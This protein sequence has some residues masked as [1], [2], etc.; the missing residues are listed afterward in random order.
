MLPKLVCTFQSSGDFLTLPKPRLPQT[1][2]SG[3]GPQAAVILE[4]LRKIPKG[5]QVW[6]QLSLTIVPSAAPV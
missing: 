2:N 3:D 5:R 1:I 4:V 6:E